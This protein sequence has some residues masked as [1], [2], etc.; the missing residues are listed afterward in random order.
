MS[1][2]GGSMTAWRSTGTPSPATPPASPR[3]PSAFAAFC[4][5]SAVHRRGVV[6]E[7]LNGIAAAVVVAPEMAGDVDRPAARG[8]EKR[9]ER[10]LGDAKGD[11]LQARRP[12]GVAESAA[13]M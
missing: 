8:G 3:S 1:F 7:Q 9:A 10:A 2:R 11:R 13:Q 4:R 6:D 12:E 5:S